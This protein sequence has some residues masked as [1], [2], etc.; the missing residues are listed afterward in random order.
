MMDPDYKCVLRGIVSNEVIS[1][2]VN[3]DFQGGR[4]FDL[5]RDISPYSRTY[6]F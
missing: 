6:I 4:I 3:E 2:E 1:I 5:E